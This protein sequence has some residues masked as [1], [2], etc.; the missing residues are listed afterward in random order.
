MGLDSVELVMAVEDEFGVT[1]FAAGEFPQTVG[2][3]HAAIREALR[4]K[5]QLS[6]GACPSIAAFFLVR[7][8]LQRVSISLARIRPTTEL[9]SL[10]PRRRRRS[11][12]TQLEQ[13]LS[14]RLPPLRSHPRFSGP[15]IL[16]G[17]GVCLFMLLFGLLTAATAGFIAAAVLGLP[18]VV[19]MTCIILRFGQTAIPE[20]CSTAGHLVHRILPSQLATTAGSRAD[21]Y[22]WNRLRQI[23]SDTLD[24]PL[25]DIRPE[26]HFVRDLKCD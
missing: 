17:L 20:H 11:M 14:V 18:I 10:L 16:V 21:E 25:A 12:W 1:F 5:L 6:S 19:A 15:I 8:A 2:E 26:S 23:V 4:E 24:V 3:M 9:D 13:E 7:D 22:N